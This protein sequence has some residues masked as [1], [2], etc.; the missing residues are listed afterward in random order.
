M[1]LIFREEPIV[2]PFSKLKLIFFLVYLIITFLS[3]L[4]G[5][6]ESVESHKLTNYWK[7]YISTK[8]YPVINGVK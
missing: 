4:K 3:L 2:Q 1:Q 5:I 7:W 8:P 6:I